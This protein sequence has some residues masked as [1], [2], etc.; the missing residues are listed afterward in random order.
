M[1][2]SPRP[3][4]GKPILATAIL[5][6]SV[7]AAIAPAQADEMHEH[8]KHV[9]GAVTVNIALDGRALALEVEAPAAQALG[10][11]RSPRDDRERA[12]AKAVEDWFR[13]GR[14][15]LAV[16]PAAGCRLTKASFTPPRLGSG[17]ADYRGSYLFDC[18]SPQALAWV[19]VRA[20]RRMQGLEQAEVNI[21][22]ATGQRQEM[23]RDG[24]VR[25]SLR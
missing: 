12:A 11:E 13:S 4:I 17:H 8:G 24:A 16:P 9:H 1:P 2:R 5:L 25:I 19:E 18:A 22:T 7:A 20:L 21:L 23:L 3:S 14:D 10:F 15:M 6:A